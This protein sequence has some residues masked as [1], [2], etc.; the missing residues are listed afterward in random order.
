MSWPIVLTPAQSSAILREVREFLKSTDGAARAHVAIM[1][2]QMERGISLD[3]EEQGLLR[4]ILLR[5]ALSMQGNDED[6]ETG[7][8]RLFGVWCIVPPYWNG[9]LKHLT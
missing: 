8:F 6:F 2:S 4:A 1:L 7:V 9:T 5:R 3:H